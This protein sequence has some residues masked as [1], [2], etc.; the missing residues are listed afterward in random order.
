M[1]NKRIE[2]FKC[3][4]TVLSRIDSLYINLADI[5]R[6][7]RDIITLFV[8]TG[9]WCEREKFNLTDVQKSILNLG[10]HIWRQKGAAGGN[11]WKRSKS[12]SKKGIM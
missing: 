4:Q 5:D 9:S 6:V 3:L 1:I 10:I 8:K 7:E 12:L 11:F 2:K